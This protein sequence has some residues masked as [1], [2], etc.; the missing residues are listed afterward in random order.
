MDKKEIF[1][2]KIRTLTD[3][4]RPRDP[5]DLAVL[6]K[7]F[8]MKIK[9][10]LELLSKKE[11]YNPLDRKKIEE[12]LKI[13]LDRF[14]EEMKELYYKELISKQEMKDLADEVLEAIV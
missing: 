2:E 14:E 12:N 13:S 10:G 7:R 5:Y 6:K 11:M 8:G 3:R 4:A 9:D 1:A